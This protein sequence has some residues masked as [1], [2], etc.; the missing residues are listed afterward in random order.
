MTPMASRATWERGASRTPHVRSRLKVPAITDGCRPSAARAASTTLSGVAAGCGPSPAPFRGAFGRQ[1]LSYDAGLDAV[2]RP[3][4][5]R[6][7]FE[8]LDAPRH[9][10]HPELVGGEPASERGADAGGRARDDRP[11]SV[12]PECAHAA[13]LPTCH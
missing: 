12:G 4:L 10:D 2:G 5:G 1:I 11:F 3:Q 8:P 7:G 6:Q 13:P 9:E